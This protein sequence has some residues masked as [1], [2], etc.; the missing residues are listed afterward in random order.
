MATA[1]AYWELTNARA[2]MPLAAK[3]EPACSG[4][5]DVKRQ[6]LLLNVNATDF[7]GGGRP[8]LR[9]TVAAATHVE[10]EPS[11]PQQGG[12]QEDVGHVVGDVLHLGAAQPEGEHK[13]RHAGGCRKGQRTMGK[14]CSDW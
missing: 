5:K 12:T 14:L 8:P 13:R 3:A 6:C 9:R 7:Y 11:K 2:A 1:G 4:P 10:S